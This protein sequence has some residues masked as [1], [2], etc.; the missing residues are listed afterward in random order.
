MKLYIYRLPDFREMRVSWKDIVRCLYRAFDL[1]SCNSNLIKPVPIHTMQEQRISRMLSY[2][3]F[4][5]ENKKSIKS[6]LTG[7]VYSHVVHD[8]YRVNTHDYTISTYGHIYIMYLYKSLVKEGTQ[9]IT[10]IFAS[11][12]IL[13]IDSK[14][15]LPSTILWRGADPLSSRLANRK[16]V[17]SVF[18]DVHLMIRPSNSG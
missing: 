11:F 12:S 9:F 14:K 10:F 15:P 1:L 8:N 4:R 6:E 18:T 2:I 3:C 5:N 16:E 7:C 13:K 17:M